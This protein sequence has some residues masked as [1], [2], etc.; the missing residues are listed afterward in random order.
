MAYW[1]YDSICITWIS[2]D[3]FSCLA[4]ITSSELRETARYFLVILDMGNWV[5]WHYVLALKT[6]FY[7]YLSLICYKRVQ[8]KCKEKKLYNVVYNR[9][10]VRDLKGEVLF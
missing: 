4:L 9:G 5:K 10:Y 3:T 6:F 2:I 1:V 7:D 8:G